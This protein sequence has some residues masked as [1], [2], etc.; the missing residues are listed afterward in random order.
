M[1]LV[2][3]VITK[4]KSPRV[5]TTKDPSASVKPINHTKKLSLGKFN[6]G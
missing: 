4:D 2:S 5:A 3:C 6:F 1:S